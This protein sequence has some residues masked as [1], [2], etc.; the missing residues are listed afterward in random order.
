MDCKQERENYE[1]NEDGDDYSEEKKQKKKKKKSKKNN[2]RKG[3]KKSKKG[4]KGRKNHLSLDFLTS[5]EKIDQG[6]R[7]RGQILDELHGKLP[8]T[9]Y[10]KLINSSWSRFEETSKVFQIRRIRC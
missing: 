8:R 7:N 1:E 10:S 9:K 4:K 5:K 6:K 3:K 2:K